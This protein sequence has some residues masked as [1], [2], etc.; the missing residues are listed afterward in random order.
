MSNIS[1]F[2]LANRNASKKLKVSRRPKRVIT[3]PDDPTNLSMTY[4]DSSKEYTAN[5][6]APSNNGGHSITKYQYFITDL[7]GNVYLFSTVTDT[8][9]TFKNTNNLSSGIYNFIVKS[10]NGTYYSSPGADVSF[11]VPS[12]PTSNV[13][14]APGNPTNVVVYTQNDNIKIASWSP[15]SN[16]G[17]SPIKSYHY[18][19]VDNSGTT[20]LTGDV[21]T[22]NVVLDTNS[23]S[24]DRIYTFTVQSY[25]GS[26][27]SSPGGSAVFYVSSSPTTNVVT[28]PSAPTNL[29]IL[30]VN[31][32][33]TASW[34]EPINNGG[35]PIT[36]Y[37]YFVSDKDGNVYLE[38]YVN[39]TSVILS[40]ALTL[41]KNIS[42]IFTVYS[43][44]GTSYSVEGASAD[45]IIFSKRSVTVTAPTDPIQVTVGGKDC[46][47]PDCN[48]VLD[49]S[50][51]TNNGGAP[52]VGYYY[53]LSY[54]NHPE[55][56]PLLENVFVPYTGDVTTTSFSAEIT[57]KE[58]LMTVR[59]FNGQ[60][61]SPGTSSGSMTTFWLDPKSYK[62][63]IKR[64][65]H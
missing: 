60:Y 9:V 44:N 40:D 54:Y 19:V 4:N 37:Q 8:F 58:Y 47:G 11:L 3:P 24:N 53:T 46:K 34:K 28:A 15:P 63:L 29:Q 31:N 25:N 42:Y 45:L 43:F 38:N 52:I 32:V 21:T 50:K 61:E 55:M 49:I 14:T 18:Y 26:Y 33:P 36:L 48:L 6:K 22:T 17:G 41:N 56:D 65:H 5:W 57:T 64:T 20:W 39:T 51:P 23:M 10:Y 30:Y 13:V 35:S 62:S 27:E 59:S 16:N 1:L 2:P 12:S 7:T